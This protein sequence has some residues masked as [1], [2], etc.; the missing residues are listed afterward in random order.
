MLHKHRTWG[1]ASVPSAVDLARKLTEHVWT[2]CTGFYA[3]DHPEVLFLNDSTSGNGAQEYAVVYRVG[4]K[5][6]QGESITFGWCS[7]EEGLAYVRKALDKTMYN[8]GYSIVRPT[9]EETG[10][11]CSDCA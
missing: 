9:L 2:P 4:T 10:H 5:L 8:M 1:L 7:F 11:R 6:I 3:K